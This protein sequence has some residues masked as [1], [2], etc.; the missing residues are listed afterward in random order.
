[1]VS[2]IAPCSCRKL[3]DLNVF[4][5]VAYSGDT[6]ILTTKLINNGIKLPIAINALLCYPNAQ[7]IKLLYN[8]LKYLNINNKLNL[9]NSIKNKTVK[10]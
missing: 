3:G 7:T 10:Y 8:F 9:C 6:N 4:F 5:S 2:Q 1:M